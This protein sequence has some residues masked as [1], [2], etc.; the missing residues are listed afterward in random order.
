VNIHWRDPNSG[1]FGISD[2]F[3]SYEDFSIQFG[4]WTLHDV[5][6]FETMVIP[7]FISRIWMSL[8]H[9]FF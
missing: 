9:I 4:D 5:D 3:E 6:M 8:G 7:G 2:D 1:N